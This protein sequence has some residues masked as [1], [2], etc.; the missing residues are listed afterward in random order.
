MLRDL[1]AQVL[2]SVYR[3]PFIGIRY[4]RFVESCLGQRYYQDRVYWN[5]SLS[6]KGWASSYLCNTFTINL[7]DSIT[8]LLARQIAPRSTSILDLGCAG[9]T[10]SLC[11]GPEFQTYWGVDISDVAI[12]KARENL[13]ESSKCSTLDYHLEVSQIQNYRPSRRFDIIVFNEVLYY[14]SMDQVATS[15]RR[16]VEFL[17]PG[18][19]ILIS[20]K[21]H[22]LCRCVQ[23][24]VMQELKF[25]YGVL[26]QQQPERPCWKIYR[27]RQTPAYLIQAFRSMK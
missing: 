16:Y 12:S 4:R 7:R 15:I 13:A 11:L 9:A 10:L 25:E 5:E 6:L 3:V 18:G 20:M 22:E 19:V 8:I 24:V 27:N 23:A 14:L 1:F 21:D 17:S 2:R 26:Y